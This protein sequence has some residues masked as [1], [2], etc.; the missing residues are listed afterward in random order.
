[1]LNVIAITPTLGAEV[2]DVDLV[3]DISEALFQSIAS[4]LW[5]Y[6]VLFFRN[7][8]LTQNEFAC[9]S[10]R[11]GSLMK[12]PVPSKRHPTIDELTQVRADETSKH[13]FGDGWH[14]DQSALAI[15][16]SLSLLYVNTLPEVGGDTLWCST[17]AAYEK[18]SEPFKALVNGLTA[19]HN[20]LKPSK[21]YILAPNGAMA[22]N[23]HPVVIRHPITGR[24]ALFVNRFATTHIPQLAWG[25]SEA[26]LGYL[27]SHIEHVRFQ[28]RFRWSKN[29][30][31]IWDNRCTQHTVVWDYFPSVREALRATVVG[32]VP[33]AA[34]PDLAVKINEPVDRKTI[35]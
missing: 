31:A 14:S 5:R 7:Q 19:F 32:E 29:T 35:R 26:L 24:N 6:Q 10:R 33:V 28:C 4:A 12:H 3:G 21:G 13:V 9:F 30:I 23:E 22:H 25:E 11:F 34:F 16:P 18:L 17:Y 2:C 8:N 20:N 1:M 27:Y 15:P